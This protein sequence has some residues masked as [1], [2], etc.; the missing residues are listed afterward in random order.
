LNLSDYA[1]LLG[2]HPLDI[3]C[4]GQ[5]VRDGNTTWD[6]L[7]QQSTGAREV[8]SRWLFQTRNRRAQD[9]RLR[10]RFE[11]DAFARMTPYW[12][13]VGFPFDHLVP[14]LAT[15]IGSSADRPIA[16]AEL[17]GIILNDGT[18]L[19][20]VR[21]RRFH[22]AVDTPY[23]TAFVHDQQSGERVMEPAVART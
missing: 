8:A 7:M 2:R 13:R 9:L 20:M 10:I 21:V 14:S 3:W 19:P 18:R 5:L 17:M 22:F 4:A 12:Q 11:Q 1:Y 6:E 15:A 23:E 16:L